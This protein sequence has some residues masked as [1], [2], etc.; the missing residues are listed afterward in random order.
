MNR[1]SNIELLRICLMLMIIAGHVMM[2]HKTSYSLTNSDEIIRL[3]FRSVF[4]VAVN[5]FVIISGYFGIQF[6]KDRLAHLII[7]TFFYSA[8]FMTL[9]IIL[10]WHT[11]NF[12]TDMF[13]FMP[14]FT[15]QYWFVTCYVVLYIISPWLNIW[16]DSLEQSMF[17]KFLVL[18]FL[19][20]FLWPTFSFLINSPRFVEDSGFGIVN[21]VYLYML[22]RYIRLHFLDK[23][24]SIYYWMGYLLS[25]MTLFL[26]Q[27]V[28]SW[29]LGFEFTSWTSYNTVLC[30]TG[31]VC[32]FM[33]FKNMSFHSSIIN[34]WAKPCL[35]VYLI[36]MAPFILGKFC[37]T[38]GVQEYHAIYYLLLIFILPF[39]IYWGCA[40]IEILR[41]KVLGG[42]ENKIVSFLV[43]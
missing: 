1:N 12:R 15:K 36:H 38:I 31:S 18:G 34:Y 30:F 13:A 19:I 3:L 4:C 8:M 33:T 7:Q 32:L 9:A 29:V 40:I 22:G 2:N 42:I 37:M 21:F 35:A 20:F 41:L 16:V 17:R 39:I 24:S 14:I 26:C 10:G 28:L 5:S 27:Y 25:V 6:K 11:I 43:E 23:H